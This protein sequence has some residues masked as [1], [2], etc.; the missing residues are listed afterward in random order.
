M[1]DP[2]DLIVTKT[3]NGNFSVGT[4]G[5][6]TIT[7]INIGGVATTGT[8]T[9][10]DTLPTGLGF[11]SA[12]GTGWTCGFASPTVTCTSTTVIA[13]N[14]QGSPISLTVSE[15]GDALESEAEAVARELTG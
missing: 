13:A 8:I 10:T 12:T 14:G 1:H 11:V 4:N 15:P 2:R 7:P 3:H 5:V 9:I 6:F